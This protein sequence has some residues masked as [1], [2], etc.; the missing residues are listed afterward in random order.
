MPTRVR[1]GRC[2]RTPPIRSNRHGQRRKSTLRKLGLKLSCVALALVLGQSSG[3]SSGLW[4]SLLHSH[5]DADRDFSV[6][7][8]RERDTGH[9]CSFTHRFACGITCPLRTELVSRRVGDRRTEPS[10][11]T[12]FCYRYSCV[13]SI[14]TKGDY[15]R[16]K[17]P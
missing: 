6:E 5:A 16:I 17:K 8:R 13:F 12:H 10:R 14:A 7:D 3:W 1:N 15:F 11:W 4:T 2:Q 9:T